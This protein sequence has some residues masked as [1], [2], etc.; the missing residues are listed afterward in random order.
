MKFYIL[1]DIHVEFENF[2]P[3]KV[4]ADA[5]IL[6][7]DIHVKNKGLIWAREKFPEKPVIY[8]LGN[9]EI[10]GGAYPRLIEKLK[11]QVQ[12]YQSKMAAL[13][14]E[15][16][17]RKAEYKTTQAMVEKLTETLP[18]VTKRAKS[19]K[20]LASK[21]L[22]A[23]NSWL[24]IKQQRI[25]QEKDL[26]AQKSRLKE[27]TAAIKTAKQ[28]KKTVEAESIKNVLAALEEAKRK[29][30]AF[31]QELVKATQRKGLRYL[32]AP[33]EGV[34]QQLAIHTI[35]GVV[36]PAQKL[37]IIVPKDQ[38]L[39]VET[40]VQNKDIGF[41]S[42]GQISEIKIDAFPFTKYGT[43]DGRIILISNDAIAD[44]KKGLIY[45]AR[46]S[47]DKKYI[48]VNNKKVQLSPG[49]SVAVEMKTGKRRLI[50]YFLSPLLKYRDESV[51][52][53]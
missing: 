44:E 33:V 27:I 8:V 30:Q 19:L 28:K 15:I 2:D 29:Q 10:Y 31:K 34:V 47:M 13:D 16:A 24:E 22:V 42:E 25:E 9:H 51:R 38:K 18:I 32:T 35:G 11:N 7:G 41:V 46:I 20:G 12:E 53:R 39:M 17:Q 49:M 40:F 36:T 3:P 26:Q 14:S 1:N 52:E 4:D 5:I 50:E 43:I 37:M 45:A 21:K 48:R 6:A 23:E